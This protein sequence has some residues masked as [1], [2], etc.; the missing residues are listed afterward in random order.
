[1]S[2]ET[3]KLELERATDP[4]RPIRVVLLGVG[5]DVNKQ[6]LDEIAATTGGRSF[7]R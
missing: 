2:L 4:T 3:L 1:M 5:P 6:E 7:R